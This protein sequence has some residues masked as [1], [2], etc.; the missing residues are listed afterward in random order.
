M[1]KYLKQRFEAYKSVL[2]GLI[3]GFIVITFL[4][5]K[6]DFKSAM[7]AIGIGLVFGEL[8]VYPRWLRNQRKKENL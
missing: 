1:K 5:E 3:F 2:I 7:I 8:I 6:P 4:F